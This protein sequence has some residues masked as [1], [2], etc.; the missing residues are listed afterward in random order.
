MRMAA[1]LPA[2]P[3]PGSAGAGAK[4]GT[5]AGAG[6]LSAQ[7]PAAPGGLAGVGAAA[8]MAAG[9]TSLLSLALIRCVDEGLEA[10]GTQCGSDRRA[11]E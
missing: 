10:A 8:A 2:T 6:G 1:E 11:K 9:G 7:G 4:A 5:G 3:Q